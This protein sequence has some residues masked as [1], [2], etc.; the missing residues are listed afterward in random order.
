MAFIL[1]LLRHIMYQSPLR[2]GDGPIGLVMVP[3]RELAQQ[4]YSDSKYLCKM[5]GIRV[6]C[7]YGGAGLAGQLSDLK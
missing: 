5:L 2:D 6:T 7:V 1:P 3:T 4:V